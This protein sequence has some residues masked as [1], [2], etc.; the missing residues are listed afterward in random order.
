[1]KTDE[2]RKR[3]LDFFKSKG[4]Q[5]FPSDS[6]IPKDDPSLLFTGAGMNQFKPYFLGLKKDVKRATSCQKCLRTA[7][8][9]RVGKTAYHHTFFEMLGNF[10][11]GDYFKEE[12]IEWGWEF[13]TKELKLPEERLWVSVYEEDN[14]A[15]NIWKN[16]I[17]VPEAR[18]VRMG[19]VDNF[20]PSNAKAD[21][22][23]G[24]CGP[25]SEIYV[26]ETPGKGVEIWNLVFTQFDRRSDA[27]LVD[28][29]QRN[30]DTGWGLSARRRCFRGSTAI[31]ILIFLRKSVRGFTRF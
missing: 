14:E 31:L 11:F 28:L 15:F 23:N 1:M 29:P 6:L 18:I 7:D 20:W 12:A 30:I 10:A 4:H 8:L 24:P 16:K 17:G 13:A 2:L 5:V 21:G 27:T 9:E 19:P 3:Y 22:P 25:C 26:G